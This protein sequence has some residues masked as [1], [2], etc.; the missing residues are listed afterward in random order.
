[1]RRPVM[2][3]LA[4]SSANKRAVAFPIP[5]VAP[6]MMATLFVSLFVIAASFIYLII[7]ISRSQ[8]NYRGPKM[9]VCGYA[10]HPHFRLSFQVH[11]P[12]RFT[13]IGRDVRDDPA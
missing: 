2:T 4:P 3:R 9:G 10:A 6:V 12:A 11:D 5:E 8:K 7:I 1:M 13:K